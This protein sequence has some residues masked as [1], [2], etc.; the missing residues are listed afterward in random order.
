MQQHNDK[1]CS[2]HYIPNPADK[3]HYQLQSRNEP[4]REFVSNG[5]VKAVP[6]IAMQPKRTETLFRATLR[7]RRRPTLNCFNSLSVILLSL[8]VA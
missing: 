6:P 8:E 4:Q 2:S 1:W 5:A 3:R 7:N